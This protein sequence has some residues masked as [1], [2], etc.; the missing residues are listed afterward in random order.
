MFS[1]SARLVQ[2]S[3]RPILRRAADK[4][5]ANVK[6]RTGPNYAPICAAILGVG[7][8]YWFWSKK[9]ADKASDKVLEKDS[10]KTNRVTE[11]PGGGGSKI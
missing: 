11:N 3:S 5:D 8:V 6:M 10:L 1:R 4:Q 2:S 7:G 9:E